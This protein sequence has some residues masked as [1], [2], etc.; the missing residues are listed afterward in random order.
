M[1]RNRQRAKQ[2]QA[3][4]R[5]ERIAQAGVDPAPPLPEDADPELIEETAHLAAGAPPE[6]EGRS[7]SVLEEPSFEEEEEVL[8]ESE[9][10]AGDQAQERDG[11]SAHR[12]GRVIAFLI[13]VWAELKRVQWPDRQTLTVLTGVVLLFV[14]IMGGYLGLLDAAFSKL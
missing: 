12:H 2:R 1:A 8:A 10:H 9:S 13:A 14:L 4:R 11:R 5:A 3:E 7:D 6:R